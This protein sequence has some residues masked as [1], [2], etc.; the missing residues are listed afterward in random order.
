MVTKQKTDDIQ[1]FNRR[2]QTYET[3]LEQWFF[4]DRVHKA[5]LN[6]VDSGANPESILDVGCGTGRLL[7]KVRERW[8]MARLM[9]VDPAEGMVEKARQLM[10]YAT[11]YIS[12][13]ESLPLPDASVDLIFSTLSF[14]HWLD[15]EQ[16]IHE[17]VRVLRPGGYFFL[18]DI[19]MPFG[20]SKIV[21]H[22]RTNDPAIIREIFARAG[23]DVQAQR[24][25]MSGFLL[26]TIGRRR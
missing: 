24:R 2:S 21:H 9:G 14:H 13:A 23:L 25:R 1:E 19:S 16:G 10:P 18:A 6:M 7:R 5:V 12:M 8:H 17:I 4:F 20:L 11:F 3:S 22:F 26:V 15:Q